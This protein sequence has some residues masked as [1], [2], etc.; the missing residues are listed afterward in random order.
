M[1][2]G[3]LFYLR[4]N[5]DKE[6]VL[7]YN[8]NRI[9]RLFKESFCDVQLYHMK[10]G[11]LLYIEPMQNKAAYK[12]YYVISG[13]AKELLTRQ[14]FTAG[15]AL[16]SH[17][18]VSISSL[19]MEEDT[20]ILVHAF[21][22]SIEKELKLNKDRLDELMEDLYLKDPYEKGHAQRV[23]EMV[24]IMGITLGFS[25]DQLYGLN[26]AARFFD[27]GKIHIDEILL[28]KESPLSFDEVEIIRF[29]VTMSDKLI[30]YYYGL[31]TSLAIL[32]HHERWD[33]SGYPSGLVGSEISI[34]AR[35]I[36][37]CDSF[38]AMTHERPYREVL[39][40]SSAVEVLKNEAGTNFDP[41]LVDLFVDCFEKGQFESIFEKMK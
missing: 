12:S 2:K 14:I 38:D 6:S 30:R 1:N 18:M 10:R 5:S 35:L 24:K 31:T 23:F 32:E 41:E 21:G 7:H 28:K 9:E 33:G 27:I 40:I 29:H 39:S 19:L 8:D 13:R 4:N 22:V 34:E 3:L 37:I 36:A 15:D 26:K 11:Q 20:E 25:G 17:K 16:L